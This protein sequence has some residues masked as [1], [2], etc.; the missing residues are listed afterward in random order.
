[1][2]EN[3]EWQ[4]KRNG[5][6]WTH[7]LLILYT[8]FG[9]II[10]YCK[11]FHN[12]WILIY[13]IVYTIKIIFMH[14]FR[15]KLSVWQLHYSYVDYQCPS[16]IQDGGSCCQMVNRQLRALTFVTISWKFSISSRRKFAISSPS[17]F[18]NLKIANMQFRNASRVHKKRT[19][20]FNTMCNAVITRLIFI[21]RRML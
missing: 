19:N 5:Y 12:L 8:I 20:S 2:Q 18:D 7:I 16:I 14:N 3:R 15:W 1:M 10:F 9:R 17:K 13:N 11:L 21:N 4:W 6:I